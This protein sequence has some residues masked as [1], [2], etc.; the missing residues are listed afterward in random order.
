MSNID[1]DR[2]DAKSLGLSKSEFIRRREAINAAA[3]EADLKTKSLCG[4]CNNKFSGTCVEC[5]ENV[6]PHQGHLEYRSRRRWGK[7]KL[8]WSRKIIVRHCSCL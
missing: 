2:E 7:L 5:G 3:K 8:P 4:K 1:R 6:H